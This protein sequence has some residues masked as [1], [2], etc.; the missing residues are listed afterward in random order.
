MSSSQSCALLHIIVCAVAARYSEAHED[1]LPV[2]AEFAR[3]LAGQALVNGR[4]T[5]EECQAFLILSVYQ[6]PRKHFDEQIHWLCMGLAFTIALELRLNDPPRR[7]ELAAFESQ[8]SDLAH[9]HYMNRIRTWLNCYC[10]DASHATQFGKPAMLDVDDYVASTCRNWY[11]MPRNLSI[12]VHLV[13]YVE[14]L[15]LVRCF[16]IEVGRI[17]AEEKQPHTAAKVPEVLDVVWK[18]HDRILELYEFW[19]KRFAEHPQAY[20]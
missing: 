3:D 15:K 2:L 11:L 1:R 9:R 10:V 17:E 12:D 19:T 16:R 4:K 13:A 5:I 6:L 14:L 18:Y 8:D 20:G 7:D